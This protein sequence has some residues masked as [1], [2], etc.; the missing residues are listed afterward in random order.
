VSK[1]LS[2][3]EVAQ[4]IGRL[5]PEAVVE[6][7]PEWVVVDSRSLVPVATLLKDAPELDC[8]YLISVTG[9]DCLDHFEVIYHWASLAHNHIVI[10]KTRALDH[11]TPEVP[12]LCSLWQGADL[13]ER[14]VYDL[15]G[16]RFSDHPD[17]RRVFLWEGYHGHPLRKDFLNLPGGFKPGLPR[18]PGVRE[19]ESGG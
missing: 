14:E 3:A 8:Q 16:I 7:A 11:D 4:V 5:L 15:M 2:G 9:V 6:E 12:S 13:Q 17:L 18:F 19:E 10:L 1:T